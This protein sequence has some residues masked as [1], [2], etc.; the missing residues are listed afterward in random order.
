[1]NMLD[2]TAIPNPKSYTRD[3][4]QGLFVRRFKKDVQEQ[5]ERAFHER[6]TT[7]HA[8]PASGAEEHA[9]DLL[10]QASFASF[11]RS[12]R[13]GQLLFRTVLE[14]ALFSSPAAC[15]ATISNRLKKL[16]SVQTPEAVHDRQVLEELARAVEAVVPERFSRYQTLLQL[17]RPGGKFNWSPQPSDDRIV[18]FT[19]RVETLKFLREQL[20]QDLKLRPDQIEV[21]HGQEG[22]DKQVQEIVENFGREQAPV[23]VLIATDI[24]SEGINLHF[25][26]HRLIHFD[27]PW[28][29]MVFQQRNG[30]VDRYGQEQ[31]PH[32]AYLCTQSSNA[33][34]RGDQRILEL[35]TEKDEQA[36][37]NIGDPSAFLGVYD[38]AQ[39]EIAT[40][41]A[42]EESLSAEQFN[43][44]M[45][46]T[47]KT[48][49]L[50]A[51]LMGDAPVE[52]GETAATR[53]RTMPSLYSTDL[54]YVIAGL[55]RDERLDSHHD[56][57]RQMVSLTVPKDLERTLKRVLPRGAMPEDGRLRLSSDR[58]LLQQKIKELRSGERRWPEVHLLWDLHPAVEWLNYKLLVNFERGHAPVITL[59][60]VLVKDELVFLLE[61]EI[62]N[63]KGQPVVHRWFGVRYERG[64]FAGV[65]ELPS[66]LERTQF[67]HKEYPNPDHEPEVTHAKTLLHEAVK[68]GQSYMSEC[69]NRVHEEIK[70]KLE[71]A[72]ARLEQL[73]QA[74]QLRLEYE[75][76]EAALA[77][78]RMRQKQ[79]RQSRIDRLFAQH[80][81]YVADTL[82]T[83]D[84]A[85]LRVAAVFRGE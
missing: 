48:V 17:L 68:H 22:D 26:S 1:M 44:H 25:L 81:A 30:R 57:D 16:A 65:E 59:K 55:A 74:K 83:E 62:P 5:M 38:Q 54:E 34:I 46:Q 82:T 56:R 45:E 20:R 7:R 9:Y 32:I 4:I 64:K 27:I 72:F 70:P 60:G 85:F 71:A 76:Q 73:Q 49:D 52:K 66:F 40:G 41:K 12:P 39:E 79:A 63:R 2:P 78:L 61:G 14:K 24:A 69:R 75:F 50:L 28:S 10:S 8:G 35:L 80:R 43:R 23:R 67:H 29:L 21:L 36:Q 31:R 6:I 13:T 77:P 42:I 19:E 18:L 33:K 58:R 15:R 3:D 51:I 53:K 37:K 47:A 84:A 11:D